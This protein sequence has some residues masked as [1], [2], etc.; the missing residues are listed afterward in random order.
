M[1]NNESD[2]RAGTERANVDKIALSSIVQPA[3]LDAFFVRYAEACKAGMNGLKKRDRR[4]KKDKKKRKKG[5][6]ETKG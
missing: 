6:G 3:Q 5:A 4:S 1:C 2:K